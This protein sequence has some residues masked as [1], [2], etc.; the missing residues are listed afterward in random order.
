MS[1]I[2]PMRFFNWDQPRM[3]LDIRPEEAFA[4][5][6]LKGALSVPIDPYDYVQDFSKHTKNPG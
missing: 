3:L 5:G 1:A 4:N 2:H 6:S